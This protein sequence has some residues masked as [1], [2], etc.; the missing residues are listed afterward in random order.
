MKLMSTKTK[1][2]ATDLTGA[3][4][5]GNPMRADTSIIEFRDK[6]GE[7]HLFD[8]LET[9]TRIV[10]GGYCNNG[11]I[12]SGYIEVEPFETFHDALVEL[13]QDLETYYDDGAQYVSRIVHNERM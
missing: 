5:I 9:G 2:A 3:K 10:F 11:F 4:R 13:Y 8:L 7:W 12:E 6:N 1:W